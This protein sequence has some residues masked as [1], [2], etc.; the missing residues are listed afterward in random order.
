MS[1][2]R[3]TLGL[4]ISTAAL[5]TQTVFARPHHPEALAKVIDRVEQSVYQGKKP[6]VVMD[7]DDTLIVTRERNLR[8]LREFAAQNDIQNA[9]PTEAGKILRVQISDIRYGLPDTL[10]GLGV[11][12]EDLTKKAGD[13]WLRR[14]FTNE[15]CALDKATPGAA[16]YLHLLVRAGAT[17]VYLTGRDVPRMHDGT[18]ANLVKNRF[19]MDPR[20]ALLMMK[21]D[22]KLDDLQFKKDSFAQIAKMGEVVGAFENEPANINAMAEAFPSADAVFLDTVH[23]PKPDVP[24]DRVEWVSDFRLR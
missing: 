21:P 24:Q 5:F 22:P 4:G 13:F 14:F 10:K 19:P 11:E 15:Y 16:K 1:N 18:A 20:Q 17:V 8:I 23:S 7:L 9:Y 12:N 6:I 2:L 3:I